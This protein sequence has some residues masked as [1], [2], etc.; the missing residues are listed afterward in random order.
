MR[1]QTVLEEIFNSLTCGIGFFLSIAALVVLVVFASFHRDAVLIVSLSIYGASL[2]LLF[3]FSTLYHCLPPG[4]A[5]HVFEIL[6]HCSIY[7]LIAGTYAPF[8]LVVL[9]G[10]WGWSLF[11]VVWGLA[12]AGILFKVFFISRFRVFSTLVYLLMGWLVLIAL[13]PLRRHLVTPGILW[14]AAGGVIFSLGAASYA[15][16]KLPFNHT[17]WHLFVLA[18]CACHFFSVLFYVIPG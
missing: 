18:G 14:L 3:L 15:F 11:G 17:I 7:I 12:I 9:K 13:E 1:R 6:D 16:E 8:T 10:A 5:K 4:K 2:V